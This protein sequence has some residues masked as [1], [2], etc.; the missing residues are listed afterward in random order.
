MSLLMEVSLGSLTS[1]DEE[2]IGQGRASRR[3]RLHPQTALLNCPGKH[4][5]CRIEN[6]CLP[7]SST[8]SSYL[9]AKFLKVR[10]C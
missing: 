2:A 7:R 10:H 9:D 3:S 8:A 1:E 5:S 4:D 6:Y